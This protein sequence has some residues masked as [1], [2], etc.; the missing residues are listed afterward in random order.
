MAFIILIVVEISKLC[1]N[2]LFDMRTNAEWK[3]MLKIQS[4]R[5]IWQWY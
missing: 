3:D 5:Q 4:L 2:F 1:T